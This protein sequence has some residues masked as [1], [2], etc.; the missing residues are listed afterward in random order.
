MSESLRR[1]SSSRQLLQN[2]ISV[3]AQRS[4]EDAEEVE[5]ERRRRSR[6]TQRG[7]RSPASWPESPQ[8]NE[9]AHNTPL[10][11]ELKPRC[12]LVLE[13]DEGFSD[14]SHRLE[15]RGEPEVQRNS[16]AGLQRPS[17]QRWKPRLEEEKRQEG[18]EEDDEDEEEKGCEAGRSSRSQEASTRPPEMSIDRKEVKMAYSS[19]VFL[20]HDA[21]LQNAAGQPDR[22]SYLV[23]GTM[24]PR[25]KACQ[26]DREEQQ[27]EE[28]QQ[29][30]QQQVEQ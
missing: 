26:V 8:C 2:L 18:E 1:K 12:C 16:G 9:L 29:V 25:G 24:R 23:A 11:E 13:E 3:T 27:Q 15:N 4:Q 22:T 21:R 28:Q 7:E 19:T 20:S 5:R 17:T 6:E 14:W 10:D 30:E